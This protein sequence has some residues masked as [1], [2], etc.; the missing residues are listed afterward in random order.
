MDRTDTVKRL[1]EE[2]LT[3]MQSEENQRRRQK[4]ERLDRIG[5]DQIRPV[6]NMDSS[7]Q[8]GDIPSTV[9]F[10]P[11]FW[12]DYFHYSLRDFYLDGQ[13]FIENY[14]RIR[15]ERFKLIDD[16]TFLDDTVPMWG[17]TVY[18]GSWL[19][20][21][22]CMFDDADPWFDQGP[23][24][25]TEADFWRIENAD[26]YKDGFMPQFI[27]AYETA[28]ELVGDSLEVLFPVFERSTVAL[29]MYLHGFENM[30][31]DLYEDPDFCEGLM[32]RIN[33]ARKRWFT[34][35][36]KYLGKK[37]PRADIFNDE[38]NVPTFSPTMYRELILPYE[39]DL[40]RFH[41][42]LNYWHSCG[43]TGPLMREI[44]KLPEIGMIHCSPWTSPKLVGDAFGNRAPLEICMTPQKHLLEATPVQM[45][46]HLVELMGEIR[47][48]TVKGFTFR[49]NTLAKQKSFAET[50]A[51]AKEWIGVAR[52]LAEDV[53]NSKI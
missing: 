24:I 45:R 47:Q 29:S 7:W 3:L 5:R 50:L 33:D 9:D 27:Q 49:A 17:T 51:K 1:L 48:T 6:P 40:C 34:E 23:I 42:G 10:P 30:L 37:I 52:Q 35:C 28:Q 43:N 8:K 16:D 14:L 25:Q 12:A 38:V 39:M 36:E 13:T 22:A 26:F 31:M 15:M 18:E 20:Q 46:D 4:W 2:Y 11:T 32:T 19:G 53:G 41:G 21:S 44:S